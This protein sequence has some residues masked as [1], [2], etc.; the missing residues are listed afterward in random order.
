MNHFVHVHNQLKWKLFIGRLNVCQICEVCQV[1]LA[2]PGVVI[3][4]MSRPVLFL[5][6][7]YFKLSSNQ[8]SL[9]YLLTCL[10]TYW[11]CSLYI[12]IYSSALTLWGRRCR[13]ERSLAACRAHHVRQEVAPTRRSDLQQQQQHRNQERTRRQ[14]HPGL[15]VANIRD[16]GVLAHEHLLFP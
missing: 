7:F 13:R 3:S 6:C 14:P 15:R 8:L 4:N 16:Y 9:T 1:R 10:L 11:Q 5:C 2:P 12:K